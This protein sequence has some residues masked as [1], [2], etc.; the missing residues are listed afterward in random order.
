MNTYGSTSIPPTSTQGGAR[1]PLPKWQTALASISLGLLTLFVGIPWLASFLFLLAVLLIVGGAYALDAVGALEPSAYSGAVY[2][3]GAMLGL[4]A[5]AWGLGAVTGTTLWTRLRTR[6]SA[7]SPR[8]SWASRHPWIVAA[9]L[10][11]LIDLVL[12]P[13]DL[14]RIADLPDGIL[15]AGVL[16]AISLAAIFLVY[17]IWRVFRHLLSAA[18]RLTRRSAFAAG[19]ITI[20]G[21]A[22]TFINVLLAPAL[23]AFV[24]AVPA[25]KTLSQPSRCSGSAFTCSRE[26]FVEVARPHRLE[27]ADAPSPAPSPPAPNLS[28]TSP[29]PA[30]S[31]DPSPYPPP[32]SHYP[33]S[34]TLQPPPGG[35]FGS[36]S[37][38][39][40]PPGPSSSFDACV[41]KLYENDPRYGVAYKVALD[42]AARR[43]N[44]RAEAEDIVHDTLIAVCLS[45]ERLE[46]VKSYFL[47]SVKNNA[48][49]AARRS[50]RFCALS[51]EPIEWV[52]EQCVVRSVE[53]QCV[54]WE[55]EAAAHDA[56]CS[57]ER[58]GR[59]V[60][61]L[62]V[63]Q[64]LSH[65]EIGAKLKVSEGTARQ[66]YHRAVESLREEFR[67]RCR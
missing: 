5:A 55:M 33:S 17:A 6:T 43:V 65:R 20:W 25:P 53:Q 63:R 38:A 19:A 13:L 22:A 14:G 15:G 28:P 49:K 35:G 58:T 41:K 21:L 8:A 40:L 2:L 44:D 29:S 54:Q 30:S 42:I 9:L 32:D 48:G 4:T 10:C 12:V 45:S 47:G 50:R 46:N 66:Y 64:D 27:P 67:L 24:E 60:V 3:T 56:L 23:V 1:P 57:L 59:T 26:M 18:W 37:T 52:P 34:S 11:A 61:E 39:Y 36:G 16:G 7:G 31:L 51:P 62:R